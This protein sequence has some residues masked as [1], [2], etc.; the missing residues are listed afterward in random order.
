MPTKATATSCSESSSV[1]AGIIPRLAALVY[2][3]LAVV[4]IALL[5]TG[6]ALAVAKLMQVTG[7]LVVA[8]DV[9]LTNSLSNSITYQLWLWLSIVS[10]YSFFWTHGGQTIGMRVWKLRLQ[11]RDGSAISLTQALIRLATAAFGLGNIAVIFD[12]QQRAF[13]DMWA[14]CEM[15]K[16]SRV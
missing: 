9:A 12:P 4:A 16:V 15:V 1:P 7:F 5:V 6:M 11:N 3:L 2:D 8:D 13:Q 10:F 14:G